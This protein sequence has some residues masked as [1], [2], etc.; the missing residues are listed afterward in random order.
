[1]LSSCCFCFWGPRSSIIVIATLLLT[2][3]LTFLLMN[4]TGISANL[5]SLGGLAIAIGLMVDGSVVVVENV[6]REARPFS[7]AAKLTDR[8]SGCPEVATPV[9][10]G[11]CIIILVFLPLMTLEGMEGKMFAPLAYTIAIA[12]GIS[13]VLSLTLSPVL[14]S[15]LLRAVANTTR[16]LVR[17]LKRPISC[18]SFEWP[19]TTDDNDLHRLLLAFIGAIGCFRFLER[20]SFPELKEGTISPNMDRVPNISLD[21]S[22]KMEMEA[23]RMNVGPGCE[24]YRFAS[25]PRRVSGRSCRL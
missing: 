17:L 23:I 22:I 15:Y 19:S 21:E 18:R 4:A 5:M 24:A 25:G 9:I 20:R 13:L 11:I 7:Q 16:L 14:S 12:L 3:A 2:P 1:M 6:F 8:L 10:F